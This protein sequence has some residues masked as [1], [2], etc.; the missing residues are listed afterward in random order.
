MRQDVHS[1]LGGVDDY[2]DVDEVVL[3]VVLRAVDDFCGQFAGEVVDAGLFG[4]LR[5]GDCDVWV[6]FDPVFELEELHQTADVRLGQLLEVGQCVSGEDEGEDIG[7]D[8]VEVPLQQEE[9]WEVVVECLDILDGCHFFKEFLHKRCPM[10]VPHDFLLFEEQIRTLIRLWLALSL[11]HFLDQ[12]LPIV[13]GVA[14]DP[15][16]VVAIVPQPEHYPLIVT[17]RELLP[18]LFVDAQD[19]QGQ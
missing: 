11:L 7:K 6:V 12:P 19:V 1:F 8:G 14:L 13:D 17:R 10:F 9:D 3:G 4:L 2:E 16:S 5:G 18:F 15:L